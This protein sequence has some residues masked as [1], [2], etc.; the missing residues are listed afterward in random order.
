MPAGELVVRQHL[1]LFLAGLDHGGHALPAVKVELAVGVGGGGGMVALDAFLPVNLAG[2]SV[3][4][5][6]DPAGIADE[7]ELL[8]D[9]DGRGC[10]GNTALVPPG[11][12]GVVA[13]AVAYGKNLG[14]HEA[15]AEEDHPVA[16]DRPGNVRETQ[17]AIVEPPELLAGGGVVAVEPVGGRGDDVLLAVD[18]ENQRRSVGLLQ[19]RVLVHLTAALG[20]PGQLAGLRIKAGDILFVASVHVK[21]DLVLPQ[22]RG[23]ARAVFVHDLELLVTPEHLCAGGVDAGG[24]VGAEVAVEPALVKERSRGGVAVELVD[25]LGLLLG[26]HLDIME[27]LAGLPVKA[28]GVQPDRLENNQR[29]AAGIGLKSFFRGFS[30]GEGLM[31]GRQPDLFARDDRR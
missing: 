31:G 7:I 12:G 19:L 28:D 16:R 8:A 25:P 29:L 21:N 15:G 20:L 5:G 6:D 26:E 2:E 23:A 11:Y 1:Q 13:F 22:D 17:H 10:L 3:Q 27:D 14:P 18:R 30:G 9:E 24:T 4:A